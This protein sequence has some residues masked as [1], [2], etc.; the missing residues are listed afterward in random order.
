MER[1]T[2]ALVRFC[3][4]DHLKGFNLENGHSAF[5]TAVRMIRR[6]RQAVGT[7]GMMMKVLDF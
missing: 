6:S 2:K 1:V 4:K 3:A 5:A 7:L